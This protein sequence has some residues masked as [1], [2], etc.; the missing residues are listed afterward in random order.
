MAVPAVVVPGGAAPGYAPADEGKGEELRKPKEG[1]KP[2]TMA[3]NRAKLIVELPA[4]AKLYVD[5]QPMR[6][7]SAVRSFNTPVLETGQV[8]YYELRA[9]VI[10]DGKPV[11]ETKRVLLRAGEVVRARFARM[12]AEPVSTVRAK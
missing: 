9:E 5:D 11:T 6:T 8:Y 10:R 3:P 2:N 7:T 12:D 4:D 1:G